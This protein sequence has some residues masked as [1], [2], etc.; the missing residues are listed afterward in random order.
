M[1]EKEERIEILT[2]SIVTTNEN[3]R[4]YQRLIDG[5]TGDRNEEN[6]KLR[7]YEDELDTLIMPKYS[8]KDFPCLDWS[9][10]NG[11][12]Y[13]DGTNRYVIIKDFKE[14]RCLEKKNNV[15]IDKFI[16]IVECKLSDIKVGDYFTH[17]TTD[18]KNDNITKYR[19]CTSVNPSWIWFDFGE[20]GYIKK[21]CIPIHNTTY[22]KLI[23]KEI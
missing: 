7:N 4:Y 5:F 11:I 20:N 2:S 19:Y 14:T 13:N 9:F 6:A 18:G 12:A 3:I 21:D 15:T 22:I 1:T 17:Y 16:D 8:A 23:L 10:G